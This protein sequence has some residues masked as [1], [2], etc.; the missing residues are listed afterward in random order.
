MELSYQRIIGCLLYLTITRP[1]IS[2]VVQTLS[3][4]MQ[5]PKRSRWDAT[6]IVIKYIKKDS[7]MGIL[8]SSLQ[9]DTLTCYCGSNRKHAQKHGY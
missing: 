7:G 4:F 9:S 1:G 2:Y 5:A 3:Q 6:I 8:M